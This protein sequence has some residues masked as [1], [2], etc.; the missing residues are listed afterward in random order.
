M[1]TVERKRRTY[2]SRAL[3]PLFIRNIKDDVIRRVLTR[4]RFH[5]TN[6][7]ILVRRIHH[8]HRNIDP[9]NIYTPNNL[10]RRSL[11]PSRILSRLI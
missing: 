4:R 7:N 10:V 5:T 8:T 11:A 2:F 6:N 3:Y 1:P 9:L